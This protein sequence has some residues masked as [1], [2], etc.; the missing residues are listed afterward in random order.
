M[1]AKLPG[2]KEDAP[3]KICAV[4]RQVRGGMLHNGLEPSKA[5]RCR[6]PMGC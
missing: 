6:A 4:L 2:N 1:I 3:T 5:E